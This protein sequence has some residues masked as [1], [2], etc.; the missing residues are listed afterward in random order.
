MTCVCV[1]VCVCVCALAHARV[2][3][4]VRP[5]TLAYVCVDGNMWVGIVCSCINNQINP[6]KLAAIPDWR[7]N[8]FKIQTF[9]FSRKVPIDQ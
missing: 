1:C 2:C 5:Y 4:H 8:A 6:V 3:A 7:L 9:L